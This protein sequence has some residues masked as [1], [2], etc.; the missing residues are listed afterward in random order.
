MMWAA[1]VFKNKWSLIASAYSKIRDDFGKSNM[2]EFLTVIED[3]VQLI[4]PEHYLDTMGWAI[5]KSDD[6]VELVRANK[7]SF[8]SNIVFTAL[9]DV[10]I[11]KYSCDVGYFDVPFNDHPLPNHG[12]SLS[13]ASNGISASSE[14]TQGHLGLG[15]AGVGNL[16]GQSDNASGETQSDEG[17]Q[18]DVSNTQSSS[19]DQ[20]QSTGPAL[21]TATH[22]NSFANNTMKSSPQTAIQNNPLTNNTVNSSLQ[23]AIQNT[24]FANNTVN[25]SLHNGNDLWAPID[26]NDIFEGPVA[27]PANFVLPAAGGA[28]TSSAPTSSITSNGPRMNPNEPLYSF[29]AEAFPFNPDD[30]FFTEFFDFDEFD[31]RDI[32]EYNPN[33]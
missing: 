33:L 29:D 28:Q 3:Y 23:T 12:A 6:T 11:I 18:Q 8:A 21:Q 5:V 20:S 9:S 31:V 24:S 32:S 4:K 22:N 2:E 13:M 16:Q 7:A 26:L 27:V 15:E 25:S 30:T 19:S 17:T 1:D 14:L 10:D